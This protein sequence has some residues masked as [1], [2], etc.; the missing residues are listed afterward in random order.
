LDTVQQVHVEWTKSVPR[1][2]L[3][4]TVMSAVAEHPPATS[5]RG[6]LKIFGV[7]QDQTGPPSFTFFV[8]RPDMVHFSYRRYLENSLRAAYKFSGSPLRM[9][10]K[11]KGTK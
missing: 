1:Y 8:N 7:A 6:K 11:G 10:F 4:R 3:R 2:D 9:R 5:G